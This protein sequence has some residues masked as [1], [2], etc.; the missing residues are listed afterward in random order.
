MAPSLI[1]SVSHIA[2]DPSLAV[3]AMVTARASKLGV[4]LDFSKAEHQALSRY[5][6]DAGNHVLIEVHSSATLQAR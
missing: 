2:A 6:N 4:V 1:V 5:T 3:G